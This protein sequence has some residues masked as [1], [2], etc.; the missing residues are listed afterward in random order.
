MAV[1]CLR[2]HGAL[3]MRQ[4]SRPPLFVHFAQVTLRAPYGLAVDQDS[5]CLW[6]A[7]KYR[8]C[9]MRLDCAQPSREPFIMD[10]PQAAYGP[11]M[12]DYALEYGLLVGC[13]GISAESGAVLALTH[14]GWVRITP[15]DFSGRVTH[16][17]WLSEGACCF[18]T[19]DDSLLWLKESPGAPAVRLTLPGN[20]RTLTAE[21]GALETLR[22]RYVQ[23]LLF[24]KTRGTLLV[25]DASLGAI[26]EINLR[27]KRFRVLAGVPTLTDSTYRSNFEGGSTAVC[28]GPIRALA[29]DLEQRLVWLDGA[30]GHL[31]RL[32]SN[33]ATD[34][35]SM[36]PKQDKFRMLGCGLQIL[37]SDFIGN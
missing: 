35:G 13:Y 3:A 29:E 37:P 26:F 17:C 2:E 15:P 27:A 11:C 32:E 1:C 20:Q 9:L 36:M 4:G 6:I 8:H 5:R 22:L 24:S 31:Y 30:S 21:F 12:L 23:G 33:V 18:V 25:A 28:L 14:S 19:R 34:L 16:C 7:D 10:L